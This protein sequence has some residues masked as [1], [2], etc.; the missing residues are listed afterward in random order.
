VLTGSVEH[1]TTSLEPNSVMLH[2]YEVKQK[3]IATK[4]T[5]KRHLES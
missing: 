4:Q 1:A 5:P 2:A 3:I